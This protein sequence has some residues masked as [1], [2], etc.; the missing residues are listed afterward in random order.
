MAQQISST[1][2]E[3][4]DYR[5]AIFYISPPQ[6]IPEYKP[7]FK[8]LTLDDMRGIA[9]DIQS[10]YAKIEQLSDL[11]QQR[12]DEIAKGFTVSLHP[13]KDAVTIQAAKRIY[14]DLDT[15][16]PKITY[17]MYRGAL[18]CLNKTGL[19]N[20]K[21]NL[22]SPD[23][24]L[25]YQRNPNKTDFG[26]LGL[27]PG[28]GRAELDSDMQTGVD[29]ID[30]EQHQKNMVLVLFE[31]MLPMIVDLVLSLVPGASGSGGEAGALPA[32]LQF[33]PGGVD[34]LL[35][36]K[37]RESQKEKFANPKGMKFGDNGPLP[38]PSSASNMDCA[39]V[40]SLYERCCNSSSDE[41]SVF[42]I[43]SRG[44]QN[45]RLDSKAWQ[46]VLDTYKPT[47][48][49]T[50]EEKLRKDLQDFNRQN[51]IKSK[52]A[53]AAEAASTGLIQ[54]IEGFLNKA[55]NPQIDK[56]SHTVPMTDGLQFENTITKTI[57]SVDT[58]NAIFTIAKDCIPCIDRLLDILELRPDLMLMGVLKLDIQA[59]LGF[60]AEIGN[61]LTSVSIYG[62][63]CGLISSLL[64]FKCIP[65]LQRIIVLL[66]ALL[67]KFAL[68]LDGL[69]DFLIQLVT[70]IFGPILGSLSALLD[71]FIQIILAPINC[72]IDELQRQVEKTTVVTPRVPA[73][74]HGLAEARRRVS[75]L[76]VAYQN[77]MRSENFAGSPG[78]GPLEYLKEL[79]EAKQKVLDL[80]ES[81]VRAGGGIGELTG[82]SKG[83]ARVA[84]MEEA[85]NAL[86]RNAKT[87]FDGA[88]TAIA[89]IPGAAMDATGKWVNELSGVG[90]PAQGIRDLY[91]DL[92]KTIEQ[93][94]VPM[95]QGLV[96]QAQ[97]YINNLIFFWTDALKK[98]CGDWLGTDLNLANKMNTKL[99]IIRIINV[100]VLLIDVLSKGKVFCNS[101][102]PAQQHLEEFVNTYMRPT[103][104]FD[105][106]MENGKIRI[107]SKVFDKETK[108]PTI[109]GVNTQVQAL[110]ELKEF[111]GE[112]L[113]TQLTTPLDVEIEVNPICLSKRGSIDPAT[114]NR[115]ISELGT[116]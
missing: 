94:I 72:I 36:K 73:E 67:M 6:E 38:I 88:A 35:V 85:Q 64:N 60:L 25:E 16:N 83:R 61:M 79:E 65:D 86:N 40:A 62:D 57:D 104:W 26:G 108:V 47:P 13:K 99:Q 90:D 66:S 8:K 98:F 92:D 68:E 34:P 52:S 41:R 96:I 12:L 4:L 51:R 110:T 55:N 43:A 100:I 114:L 33:N 54:D 78:K 14:P 42:A 30:M 116:A 45:T 7:P 84:Q 95:V 103:N 93:E 10:D 18:D 29:E 37:V 48:K 81:S 9:A 111:G 97:E 112:T 22:V 44:V 82:L 31:Q 70:P 63:I 28:M 1:D 15:K 53:D 21:K 91:K 11:T 24:L 32:E 23:K 77:S 74:T 71:Q 5:P 89:S 56:E 46:S 106:T 75:E 115:W 107:R 109:P 58:K 19:Q 39:V 2:R 76:E 50:A 113:L 87:A 17:E 20:A 101:E 69:L 59:R 80:E 3:A 105:A 102:S 27:E 49:E